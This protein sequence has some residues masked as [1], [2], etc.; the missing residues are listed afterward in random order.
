MEHVRGWCSRAIAEGRLYFV[1]GRLFADVGGCRACVGIGNL[2]VRQGQ[3]VAEVAWQATDAE[4]VV[5]KTGRSSHAPSDSWCAWIWLFEEESGEVF[6]PPDIVFNELLIELK[7][8][9]L[10]FRLIGMSSFSSQGEV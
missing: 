2:F 8:L 4:L 9:Q 7:S 1:V 3:R 5:M 6:L 10:R